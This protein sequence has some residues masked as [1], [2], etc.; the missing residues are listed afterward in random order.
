METRSKIL[1]EIQRQVRTYA[2]LPGQVARAVAARCR[3][4]PAN[5]DEYLAGRRVGTQADWSIGGT[6]LE[7]M[8]D[9]IWARYVEE[10]QVKSRR[11]GRCL[12]PRHPGVPGREHTILN[13]RRE[14]FLEL[15]RL[16]QPELVAGQVTPRHP[17]RHIRRGAGR[18]KHGSTGLSIL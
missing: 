12:A 18:T 13:L 7:I 2:I 15:V 9:I 16:S 17:Q 6:V 3:V 8:G 1:T 14:D 10:R 5:V 11:R 4:A